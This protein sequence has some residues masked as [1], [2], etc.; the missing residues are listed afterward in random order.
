VPL[1]EELDDATVEDQDHL[2]L[3]QVVERELAHRGEGT[4]GLSVLTAID[5][6]GT[7]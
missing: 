6:S 2:T 7:G 1:R 4:R 3:E 5:P